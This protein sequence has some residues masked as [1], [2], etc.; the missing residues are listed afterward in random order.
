M[1]SVIQKPARVHTAVSLC[2]TS[3]P[4]DT[5][6]HCNASLTHGNSN[7][8]RS[9]LESSRLEMLEADEMSDIDSAL[10]FSDSS[11]EWSESSFDSKVY[12]PSDPNWVGDLY[13][14]CAATP[15][16]WSSVLARL[17]NLK[18]H[19]CYNEVFFLSDRE[20]Q[21]V[22]EIY[23]PDYNSWFSNEIG[24]PMSAVIHKAILNQAPFKV[25]EKLIEVT[26]KFEHIQGH[27]L[28]LREE[29]Q[30]NTAV[31]LAAKVCDDL[32][33]INLLIASRPE[34]LMLQNVHGQTPLEYAK[35]NE[36]RAPPS[37]IHKSVR[38]QQGEERENH[39]DILGLLEKKTLLYM[40]REVQMCVHLC[41]RSFFV[42]GNYTPFCPLDRIISTLDSE[43][44]FSLSV[45]GYFLQS[46]GLKLLA[47]NVMSFIGPYSKDE[48]SIFNI[49][50]KKRGYDISTLLNVR[51]RSLK[52]LRS[53]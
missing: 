27:I 18:C 17:S 51:H 4:F 5:N 28:D 43:S 15:P 50:H 41:A 29:D 6:G 11:S 38:L 49:Y 9:T 2:S 1:G 16:R 35:S 14:L 30:G 31:H 22:D 48:Y 34:A 37:L 10:Y 12:S 47:L 7:M 36:L 13:D 42:L 52:R 24:R 44:Y 40:S 8:P 21:L 20:F 45:I 39:Y 23:D 32:E 46:P 3:Q 25:I 53:H 33:I 19:D 26:E